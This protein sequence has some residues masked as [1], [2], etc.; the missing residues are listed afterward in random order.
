MSTDFRTADLN[1]RRISDAFRA[2]IDVRALLRPFLIINL[3]I[4][5]LLK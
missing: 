3:L 2:L 1:T 4:I 5:G